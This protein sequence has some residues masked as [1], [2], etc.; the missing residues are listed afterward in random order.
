MPRNFPTRSKGLTDVRAFS[1][2]SRPGRSSPSVELQHS[3][4]SNIESVSRAVSLVLR[5][6]SK[7]RRLDGSEASIELA[8][9][10]A[11]TNAVV[12]GNH[13]D[14]NKR[15]YLA[16]R[17][18]K[19]GEVSITVRDQ[20]EGFDWHAIADPISQENRLATHG[21]GVYLMH[22]LMDEVSFAE[23]GVVVRMR[24]DANVRP[25]ASRRSQ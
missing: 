7:F 9:H 12:H 18:S 11:L 24:M 8:L 4:R 19:D 2:L 6:I 3:L 22:A 25:A 5:F 15:V 21:R 14:A 1:P 17:C 13:Q 16:C 23:G 20:G 10:E